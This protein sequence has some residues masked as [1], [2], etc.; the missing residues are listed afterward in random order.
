MNIQILSRKVICSNDNSI[1]NY[2][3]WPT[4]ARLQD[5]RLAMV[6]SGFRLTHRCPFGKVV[7][8]YSSDEGQTWTKPAVVIDTPLDD[9]DGGITVF[10][11]ENVMVTSFTN[12]LQVQR[13]W[14]S[15]DP[16]HP[17]YRTAYLD[18]VER[19]DRWK[20][21][22]GSTFSISRDGGN[23]FGPVR[24]IPVTCP[25]GP[26]ALKDGSLLYVG[27]RFDDPMIPSEP[28]NAI[29]CYKVA[30]DGSYTYLSEIQNIDGLMSC[31][32]FAIEL[33]SGK[34]LVHIRVQDEK[35]SCFTIYQCESYD[36]GQSF[37]LPHRILAPKGGAPA[38]LL[39]H[40]HTLICTTGYRAKPY[41]VRVAFSRD[42][43]ES[44]DTDHV[45]VEDGATWDVG[46]PATV[47]LAD[48]R[49]LTVYYGKET[50]TAPAVI[51][52]VIWTY[53]A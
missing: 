31:E 42:A 6:A 11:R 16:D 45:L 27:T 51:R 28:G 26:A 50:E 53:E 33:E 23:T 47:S 20:Q 43:G 25:H 29:Q 39:E 9:R 46:Y 15:D 38:H 1:H 37:T 7:I 18:I 21:Y 22:L 4:V 8:C 34:I 52:Q 3:A 44:W 12:S 49:L 10:G 14:A 40:N 2:F 41:G 17:A 5:G 35:R 13:G 30:P 36:G 32:P 48:G 19:E 24:R